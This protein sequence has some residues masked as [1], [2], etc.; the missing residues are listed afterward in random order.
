MILGDSERI[1]AHPLGK[2]WVMFADYCALDRHRD[3]LRLA[4]GFPHYLRYR[5]HLR[6]RLALIPALFGGGLRR[7]ARPR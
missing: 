2:Q 7:L 4:W 1:Y 6:G 5:W 3:P